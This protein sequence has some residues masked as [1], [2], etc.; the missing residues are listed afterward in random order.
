MYEVIFN[1]RSAAPVAKMD[2]TAVLTAA[3]SGDAARQKAAEETLNTQGSSNYAP[4]LVLLA[5]ELANESKPADIRQL[6]GILLKNA[7]YSSDEGRAAEKA[8]KWAA[9]DAGCKASIRA[10]R[11]AT[12]NS[13]V[14]LTAGRQL[15]ASSLGG[16]SLPPRP[17]TRPPSG[18]R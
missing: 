12:L 4:F 6:A 3:Q 16:G 18:R 1:Y 15:M 2:L 7:V 17:L 10:A 5:A 14:R 9:V 13:P 8:A 11:L